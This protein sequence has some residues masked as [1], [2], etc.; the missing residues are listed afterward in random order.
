LTMWTLVAIG[1]RAPDNRASTLPYSWHTYSF[2]LAR[3]AALILIQELGT[4]RPQA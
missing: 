4:G 1:G 3:M 2:C